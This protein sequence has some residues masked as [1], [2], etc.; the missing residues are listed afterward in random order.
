[1]KKVKT[2]NMITSRVTKRL[3]YKLC[4]ILAQNSRA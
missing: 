3:V 4:L 1:M 2:Q